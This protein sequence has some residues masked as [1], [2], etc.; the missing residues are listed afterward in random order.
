MTSE[1]Q[2]RAIQKYKKRT[3]VLLSVD[4]NISTD[5]DIIEWLSRQD[6]KQTAVKRAIRAEITRASHEQGANA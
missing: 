6:R 5:S 1:A 3:R 4:L 2:K